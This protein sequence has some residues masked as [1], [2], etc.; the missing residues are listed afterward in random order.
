MENEPEDA[1]TG[2]ELLRELIRKPP[3]ER[4]EGSPIHR[5][6]WVDGLTQLFF[7][8]AFKTRTGI[9]TRVLETIVADGDYGMEAVEVST[10]GT[11]WQTVWLQAFRRDANQFTNE[12]VEAAAKLADRL[13]TVAFEPGTQIAPDRTAT[14]RVDYLVRCSS[15]LPL[16]KVLDT[17]RIQL[18][19]MRQYFLVDTSEHVLK[20]TVTWNST[21]VP[22]LAA[23][24][25]PLGLDLKIVNDW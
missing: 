14:I 1:V 13:S 23:A 5:Q 16:V 21:F 10:V 8:A 19:A 7:M 20:L 3:K 9:L 11:S 24:L 18:K 22:D 6:V 2:N 4:L 12:Q 17:H 25:A 15:L